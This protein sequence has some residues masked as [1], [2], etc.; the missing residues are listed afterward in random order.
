MISR[1]C[2]VSVKTILLVCFLPM[3]FLCFDKL[4]AQS[5]TQWDNTQDKVWPDEFKEVEINSTVDGKTQKAY[6][7]ATTNKK[8][9][10]LIISLHTWSGDYKQKDPLISQILENDWNYIH[11]D[12]RGQNWTQEACGSP[13]VV[14]DIDDAIDFAISAG[15]VDTTNIHVVGVSGGGYATLLTYMQS[16]H[17]ICTFSAW[18]AISDI[19]AW[20]HETR[21]RQLNYAR[22]ISLATTGD[23]TG[24][25]VE[26]AK[27]RSPLFM[28]TPAEKR[29]GNKLFIYTGVHDGYTGSVPITHSINMYNKVVSETDPANVLDL[30]PEQAIDKITITRSLPGQEYGYLDDRK[31]HY[32][33]NHDNRIFITLFEGTHEMLTEV[34]LNHVPGENI[35]AIGDSNGKMSG[36]W[37]DQL[38]SIRVKDVIINE[39][40]SG[41]TIGFINNGNPML[42]TVLNIESY[43]KKH[44]PNKGR[45]NR[46]LILLGTNDCKAV[47][48]DRMDEVPDKFQELLDIIRNYYRGYDVPDILMISAPPYGPNE[49]LLD[50]YKGAGERVQ[51]LNQQLHKVAKKNQ[52][53]YLDVHSPLRSVIRF[54]SK[55]GVHLTPAGH[56][57]IA[58]MIN[59][60]LN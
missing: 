23:T 46:I 44:D 7:Y 34:A 15:N 32:M 5:G 16:R 39:S 40:V 48:K 50:K 28:Q 31:I 2:V 26:S 51:N 42:N 22:H 17:E 3:L 10:P 57:I 60:K 9:Q 8:D 33:T 21:A 35:L 30:V 12:F 37:V 53:R 49:I 19:N 55:D 13:L 58:E 24:I 59:E 43:L 38:T 47:F 36:G 45:L 11:P 27:Q 20:Y 1:F 4:R 6:Y 52:V 56:Q 18:S 54:V 29:V 41:N 14:S 25:D